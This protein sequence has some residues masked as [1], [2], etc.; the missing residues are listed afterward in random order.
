MGELEHPAPVPP[1][2]TTHDAATGAVDVGGAFVPGA[3]NPGHVVANA[4]V[5]SSP[6][7]VPVVGVGVES[8]LRGRQL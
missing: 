7:S 5:G 4:A 1:V 6:H 3:A 2:A 8:V